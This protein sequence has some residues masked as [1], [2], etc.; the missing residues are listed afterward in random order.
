MNTKHEFAQR[1]IT[2]MEKAGYAAKPSILEREFNLRYWGNPVTLQGVR[3]W[4]KGEAI[5]S[6]DKLE[7]LAEWLQVDKRYLRFGVCVKEN[8]SLAVP[9]IFSRLSNEE[10]EIIKMFLSLDAKKRKVI[11]D[12][13]KAFSDT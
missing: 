12:V 2:A 11:T 1:L 4:L 10:I 6:E 8:Y 5:P 9:S 13:I 3:R 7:V